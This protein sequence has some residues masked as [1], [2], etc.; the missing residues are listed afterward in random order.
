MS[1]AD[2]IMYPN[3]EPNLNEP[4]GPVDESGLV[5][6]PNSP[7]NSGLFGEPN[8]PDNSGLVG[9]DR[10]DFVD[11]AGTTGAYGTG[12]AGGIGGYGSDGNTAARY[13]TSG[14]TD[15]AG[16]T[17]YGARGMSAG[18]E[19]DIGQISGELPDQQLLQPG[20]NPQIGDAGRLQDI[21]RGGPNP[22]GWSEA[23]GQSGTRDRTGSFDQ[24]LYSGRNDDN[25]PAGP[26][27]DMRPN[28]TDD[29]TGY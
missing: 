6:E 4:I 7:N 20:Y 16:P 26:D 29:K 22:E 12:N 17:G 9:R 14:D 24:G 27:A 15:I 28:D 25:A 19:D 5:G 10:T 2:Q 1:N 8:S 18:G 23:S 21:E 13:G 11:T 3:D